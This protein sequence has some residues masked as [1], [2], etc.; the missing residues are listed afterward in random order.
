MPTK[1]N[2]IGGRGGARPGAGRKK[3]AVLEKAAAEAKEQE[4]AAKDGCPAHAGIGPADHRR[5]GP[6]RRLPRTRGDRPYR[7]RIYFAQYVV[8]PHTRG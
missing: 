2:N 6:C 1:S 4:E 3:K 5:R 8:A 7:I